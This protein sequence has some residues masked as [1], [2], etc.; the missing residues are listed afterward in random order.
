M[1]LNLR[2]LRYFKWNDIFKLLS[3]NYTS[4]Y[5]TSVTAYKTYGM[6]SKQSRLFY[7]FHGPKIFLAHVSELR[8][9]NYC[10]ELQLS[11]PNQF[12]RKICKFESSKTAIRWQKLRKK[13]DVN[14][15]KIICRTELDTGAG[16][17]VRA[18]E[19]HSTLEP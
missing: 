4:Y 13:T 6:Y 2:L 5:L 19:I 9:Q 3:T 1:T 10:C 12:A 15:C 17:M 7:Y 16:E 11:Y 8:H 14:R 18:V